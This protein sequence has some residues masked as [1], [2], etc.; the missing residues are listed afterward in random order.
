MNAGLNL[1]SMLKPPAN[2]FVGQT[3]LSLQLTRARTGTC[4]GSSFGVETHAHACPHLS[5]NK[6]KKTQ[7]RS[8][9]RAT[10]PMGLSSNRH[11]VRLL[12]ILSTLATA[13]L[14][15]VIISLPVRFCQRRRLASWAQSMGVPVPAPLLVLVVAHA[16]RTFTE[17]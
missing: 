1:D 17:N 5:A 6:T 10:D 15:S 2:N 11:R 16:Q 3:S 4:A 8:F 12:L 9:G 7:T 13:S 14:D